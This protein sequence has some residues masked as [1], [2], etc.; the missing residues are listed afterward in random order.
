MDSKKQKFLKEMDKYAEEKS[1]YELPLSNSLLFLFMS[2]V[3]LMASNDIWREFVKYDFHFGYLYTSL[4]FFLPS[5]I[6]M[7]SSFKSLCVKYKIRKEYRTDSKEK[8]ISLIIN[9]C[10]TDEILEYYNSSSDI[11]KMEYLELIFEREILNELN[12]KDDYNNLDLLKKL[13]K[14]I[15]IKNT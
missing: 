12:L 13:K 11:F 7:W 14:N 1:K 3:L 9:N 15:E 6:L 4:L 10:T 8:M 2:F 5:I